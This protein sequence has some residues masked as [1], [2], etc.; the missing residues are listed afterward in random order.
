MKVYF[1]AQ[2]EHSNT[3]LEKL[4]HHK[5]KVNN[6]SKPHFTLPLVPGSPFAIFLNEGTGQWSGKGFNSSMKPFQTSLY[7]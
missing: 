5:V 3:E 4:K 2:T 7:W 1:Q 6:G